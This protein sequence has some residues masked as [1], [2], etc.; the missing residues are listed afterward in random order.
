M[1]TLVRQRGS[2]KDRL[3]RF[4]DYLRGI[5][6]KIETNNRVLENSSI[7]NRKSK[8][9]ESEAEHITEFDKKYYETIS[10]AENILEKL[11]SH[12]NLP[13]KSSSVF[14]CH[15]VLITGPVAV[16]SDVVSINGGSQSSSSAVHKDLLI[17]LI[18]E[19]EAFTDVHKL[20]YL[21]ASLTGKAA[22]TVKSL[23]IGS[24]NYQIAW[25]SM[26][27]R[28]NNSRI[29]VHNHI[30]ASFN[31]EVSAKESSVKLR[32]LIDSVKKNIRA[33]D[34]L[35]N[36]ENQRNAFL[37]YLIIS[38]LDPTT[39]REFENKNDS[40][41]FPSYE[42]LIRFIEKKAS[43]LETIDQR[44]QKPHAERLTAKAFVSTAICCPLCKDSHSLNSCESLKQFGLKE[45]SEKAEELKVC[46]S[47]L[48]KGH[49]TG[50]CKSRYNCQRCKSRHHTLLHQ[51]ES[52]ASVSSA[53]AEQPT[54]NLSAFGSNQ[55]TVLLATAIL[56]ILDSGGNSHPARALLD[57]GSMSNFISGSLCKRLQLSRFPVKLQIREINSAATSTDSRC[58]VEVISNNSR[59]QIKSSC[60]VIPHITDNIPEA[61]VDITG[62]DLLA[63]IHF[64]DKKFNVPGKIDILLGAS[65]FWKIVC[66]GRRSLG[67]G[68][69]YCKQLD[70][71]GLI[72]KTLL[73]TFLRKNLEDKPEQ[74]SNLKVN[75]H[76]VAP[77]APHFGGLWEVS[78]KS[79]KYHIRHVAGNA[80]LIFE[81]MYT[82]V[83]SILHSRSLCPLLTDP[84]DLN[85]KVIGVCT[86]FWCFYG[87]KKSINPIP[88]GSANSK[89][90]VT[91]MNLGRVI[92]LHPGKNTSVEGRQSK[93]PLASSSVPFSKVG[94]LP[95]DQV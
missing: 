73:G 89:A 37:I 8:D 9:H 38:K 60:L 66:I 49:F 81:E 94:P 28:F 27:V 30:K 7:T 36:E 57:S 75:W 86:R 1:D 47:C 5:K 10:D 33:L 80:S 32:Q 78:V 4:E 14:S 35:V 18:H 41:K 21:R 23:A 93:P 61:K 90:F 22:E 3:T 77:H 34:S 95:K 45:R 11:F 6:T 40:D 71:D 43:L 74:A 50:K 52:V 13:A 63:N 85:W 19:N 42:E 46:Y 56:R 67:P 12:G 76:F 15:G 53:E 59:F 25:D 54:V 29:F 79:V 88:K 92:A 83:K 20:H 55:T 31:I 68:K 70:S 51:V 84:D 2:V 72:A 87:S 91:E 82:Q 65:C 17:N 39:T 69:P 26:N 62:C 58:N 44:Y 24:A 64:A 48:A 16:T